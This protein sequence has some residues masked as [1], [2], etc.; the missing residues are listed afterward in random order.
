MPGQVAFTLFDVGQFMKVGPADTQVDELLRILVG[1]VSLPM[2][3]LTP[4]PNHLPS[5]QCLFTCD[6]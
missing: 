4:G 3:R 2:A 5:M 1:T 6:T